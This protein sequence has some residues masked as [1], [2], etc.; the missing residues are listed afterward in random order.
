M[1][2]GRP[3][4]PPG[5]RRSPPPGGEGGMGEGAHAGRVLPASG[6]DRWACSRR[7][8]A[9]H[10]PRLCSGSAARTTNAHTV[11]LGR[12]AT[13]GDATDRW[14]TL[15]GNVRVHRRSSPRR[16]PAPAIFLLWLF[17]NDQMSAAFN[18]F[19]VPLLGFLFL[20]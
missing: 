4:R 6:D 3:K 15:R 9:E 14:P 18:W 10:G 19:W 12:P 13:G 7:A 17:D 8:R 5:T 16:S 11:S 1:D 2:L 20:P